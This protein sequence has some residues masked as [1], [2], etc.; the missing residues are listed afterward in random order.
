MM[1]HLLFNTFFNFNLTFLVAHLPTGLSVLPNF[2][3]YFSL[4]IDKFTLQV[5]HRR[6]DGDTAH[7]SVFPKI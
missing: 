1:S 5:V 2:P 3:R 7:D 4:D 6:E